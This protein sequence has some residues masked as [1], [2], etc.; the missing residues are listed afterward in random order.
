MR[1]AAAAAAAAC[2]ESVSI[3]RSAVGL[4]VQAAQ[5]PLCTFKYDCCLKMT[6]RSNL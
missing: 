5:D 1:V 2:F 6:E 3:I 4:L